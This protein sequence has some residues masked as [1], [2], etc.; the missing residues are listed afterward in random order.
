MDRYWRQAWAD[1]LETHSVKPASVPTI[2][3]EASPD[4]DE[5]TMDIDEQSERQQADERLVDELSVAEQPADTQSPSQVQE[6]TQTSSQAAT[7][8]IH[9]GPIESS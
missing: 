1:H 3:N 4:L 7:V 2:A 8:P 5:Q 6:D 9:E